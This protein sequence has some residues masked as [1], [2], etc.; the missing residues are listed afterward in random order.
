MICTSEIISS[1]IYLYCCSKESWIN[2]FTYKHYFNEHSFGKSIEPPCWWKFNND[3]NNKTNAVTSVLGKG[4]CS[5]AGKRT[6]RRSI[7]V[8]RCASSFC[9]ASPPSTE[10]DRCSKKMVQ[11]EQGTYLNCTMVYK[12]IQFFSPLNN[13]M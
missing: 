1:L 7:T 4:G 10:I 3:N 6:E 13:K 9:D 8:R 2:L 5:M 11:K 12:I